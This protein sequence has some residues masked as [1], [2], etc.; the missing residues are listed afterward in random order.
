[1]AFAIG[2]PMISVWVIG[3]P[4]FIYF[5]IR[6]H[7]DNLNNDETMKMYGLFYVG[8]NDNAYHWEVLIVNLRKIAFIICST[9]IQS[10]ALEIKVNIYSVITL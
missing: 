9:V 8:L 3:F 2:I 4:L 5:M 1:M 6:K 10:V 7:R